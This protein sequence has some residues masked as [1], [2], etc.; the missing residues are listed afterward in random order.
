M[1]TVSSANN[2]GYYSELILRG[3]PFTY[4]M[5]NKDPRIDP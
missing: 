4:I 2:A 3:R 1:T 5:K